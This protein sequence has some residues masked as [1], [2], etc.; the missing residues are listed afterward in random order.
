MNRFRTW[1]KVSRMFWARWM[2][3]PKV[4]G[5]LCS[6]L[7]MGLEIFNHEQAI[8]GDLP[9]PEWS[10]SLNQFVGPYINDTLSIWEIRYSWCLADSVLAISQIMVTSLRLYASRTTH[11]ERR[12]TRTAI[13]ISHYPIRFPLP[14]TLN[15]LHPTDFGALAAN[16]LVYG[17]FWSA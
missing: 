10:R 14:L 17:P 8:H 1:V 3:T 4:S 9:F 2:L 12:H 13:G 15:S 11:T 6:M 7:N 5:L 16:Q